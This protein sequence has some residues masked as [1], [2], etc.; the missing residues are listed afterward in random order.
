MTAFG[1]IK[2]D[3][4]GV[5]TDAQVAALV[6]AI[7]AILE[8]EAARPVDPLPAVYR[9]AWRSEAIRDALDAGTVR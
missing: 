7:S 5:P 6:A 4:G 8:E 2:V 9:S 1:S 3:K